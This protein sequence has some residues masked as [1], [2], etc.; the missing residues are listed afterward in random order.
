L[1]SQNKFDR[2]LTQGLEISKFCETKLDRVP[3]IMMVMYGKLKEI[4]ITS[5]SMHNF[6]LD[7][8]AYLI[9]YVYHM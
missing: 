2:V 9:L 4:L 7:L 6:L 3:K 8:F 1:K 5:L